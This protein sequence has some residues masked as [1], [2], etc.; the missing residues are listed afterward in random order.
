MGL[1]PTASPFAY[2]VLMT[3]ERTSEWFRAPVGMGMPSLALVAHAERLLV[4]FYGLEP[5]ASPGVGH[6]QSVEE[7]VENAWGTSLIGRRSRPLQAMLFFRTNYLSFSL[8]IEQLPAL[9][10]S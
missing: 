5:D 3:I 7:D 6:L 1:L 10:A 8:P 4:G 9:I 2:P